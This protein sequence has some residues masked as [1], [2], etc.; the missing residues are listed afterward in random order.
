M[1]TIL[2]TVVWVVIAYS[3][4]HADVVVP[5]E[6]VTNH[7]TIRAQATSQSPEVGQLGLGQQLPFVQSV[8]RWYEVQLAN[9]QT[10]FVPKSWTRRVDVT[11]PGALPA[12]QPD[13]LRI[14]FL[15]TGAGTCTVVECPGAG[16]PPMVIDCGSKGLGPN[17]LDEA[18]G[19][20]E[21]QRILGLHPST[22]PNL[23]VSHSDSD[24]LNYLEDALTGTQLDHIWLG[25]ANQIQ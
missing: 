19:S 6:R 17:D 9:T 4:V 23:V 21:I 5:S 1:K 25:V 8:S 2:F 7:V 12:R 16:A 20:A 10:G 3:F 15:N 11:P 22:R 24:H 14:H 13:E 18:A